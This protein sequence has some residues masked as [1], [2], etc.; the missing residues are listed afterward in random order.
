MTSDP[1]NTAWHPFSSIEVFTY[2][3]LCYYCC[4]G[5]VKPNVLIAETRDKPVLGREG[6]V[7]GLCS[8]YFF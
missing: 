6:A 5:V 2:I 7:G 8:F 3:Y 1:S 4:V